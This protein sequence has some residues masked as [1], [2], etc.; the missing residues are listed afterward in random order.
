M[1]MIGWIGTGL[2]LA[3][4]AGVT[5]SWRA[6]RA[7][8][9]RHP[10]TG[11]F[12]TI[13][14]GQLHLVDRPAMGTQQGT[15]LFVHGASSNHADLLATLGPGL[16][17]RFRLISPDRPGH[18]WSD[19][20]GGSQASRPSFQ[21]KLLAQ[22]I[23]R[24]GAG[25]VIVVAH[26]L[27][28]AAALSLALQRPDLVGGVVLLG[29]VTHPWPGGIEWYYTAASLPVIGPLFAWAIAVP[30]ATVQLPAGA[31]SVFTPTPVTPGYLDTAKIKL[32]LRPSAF[33]ANAQDVAA[34][35]PAVAAQQADYG[36]LA[37]PVTAF[38]GLEDTVT[39]ASI[40][41]QPL[42]DAVRDGRFVPLPGVGHMPHHAAGEQ[43]IAE[44]E[45]MAAAMR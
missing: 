25:R 26:S 42:A 38:H 41:S 32:L 4:L 30:V 39:W 1:R 44:I 2:M 35:K 27:G 34:L 37:M 33:V 36:R 40:H 16:N 11:L 15:V 20:I 21:A 6:A 3:A 9:A 17:D 8:E 23:E 28:G 19:R 12:E 14:G 7:A 18:G 24:R 45:R 43:I 22:L 13:E 31:Q 5:V 10:P 29:P